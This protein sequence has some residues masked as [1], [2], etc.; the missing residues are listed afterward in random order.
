MADTTGSVSRP[1]SFPIAGTAPEIPFLADTREPPAG[2]A[3]AVW[4]VD[5]ARRP[6]GVG[7][8]PLHFQ[9]FGGEGAG[10]LEG[11]GVFVPH[12]VEAGSGL[13][14]IVGTDTRWK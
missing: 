13:V 7:L 5:R 6:G 2:H 11:A 10:G 3:G 12:R 14:S 1:G 4:A 8:S 9:G